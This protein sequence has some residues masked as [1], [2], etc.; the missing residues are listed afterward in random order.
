[1]FQ[2]DTRCA[3]WNIQCARRTLRAPGGFPYISPKGGQNKRK[4]IIRNRR[5]GWS[6]RRQASTLACI[7]SAAH[8][9][10]LTGIQTISLFPRESPGKEKQTADL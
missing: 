8:A 5:V 9:L 1:M 10:L 6:S 7:R 2:M 4:E 3:I